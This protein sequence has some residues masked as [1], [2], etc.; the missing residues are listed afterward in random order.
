MILAYSN[1][2]HGGPVGFGSQVHSPS[3]KTGNTQ[4]AVLYFTQHREGKIA[5]KMFTPKDQV[6]HNITPP[7]FTFNI[8]PTFVTFVPLT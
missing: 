2:A 8:T 1:V 4:N 5:K 3:P 6:I 7:D